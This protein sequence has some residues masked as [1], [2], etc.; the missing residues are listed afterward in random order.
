M[1]TPTR[2][3]TRPWRAWLSGGAETPARPAPHSPRA[4]SSRRRP[5]SVPAVASRDPRPVGHCRVGSCHSSPA[6][7]L[8]HRFGTA[9]GPSYAQGVSVPAP[10][11][12]PCRVG[13]MRSTAG[14]LGRL[15]LTG[16]G[17][18]GYVATGDRTG[19]SPRGAQSRV[20]TSLLQIHLGC[21]SQLKFN[22]RHGSAEFQRAPEHRP[23]RSRALPMT[24]DRELPALRSTRNPLRT[25]VQGCVLGPLCAGP[26]GSNRH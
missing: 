9:A 24:L 13:L 12:E 23:P 2:T 17:R 11:G 10:P 18:A 7:R 20:R 15:P 14:L 4:R 6:V 25:A 22:P 3:R 19:R 26:H 5:R 21:T 16:L 8:L 1:P